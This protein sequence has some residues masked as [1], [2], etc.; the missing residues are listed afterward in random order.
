MIELQFVTRDFLVQR[1]EIRTLQSYEILQI[2]GI[3]L[4][5]KTL[6]KDL[7]RK[8]KSNNIKEQNNLDGSNL[9]SNYNF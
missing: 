6:L 7:F 1:F 2:L 8:T 3:S 9:F 5:D 4:T